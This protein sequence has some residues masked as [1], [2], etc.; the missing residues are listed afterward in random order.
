MSTGYSFAQ[1]ENK[2][3]SDR[4]NDREK[5][6]FDPSVLLQLISRLA[7]HDPRTVL[8]SI[9]GYYTA[10]AS[11]CKDP[12]NEKWVDLLFEALSG[13]LEA[14]SNDGWS[15]SLLLGDFDTDE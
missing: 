10:L 11:L 13:P 14:V 15:S 8:N 9:D 2:T 12:R 1:I 7:A 4:L 3:C 6:P 5:T